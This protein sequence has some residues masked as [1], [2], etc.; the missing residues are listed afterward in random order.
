MRSKFILFILF[1]FCARSPG[2]EQEPFE[3]KA[4]QDEEGGKMPYR[5]FIPE[6]YKKDKKYP[7][8]I[9]LHGKG[10]KGNDNLKQI[11]TPGARVHAAVRVNV[12]ADRVSGPKAAGY[13]AEVG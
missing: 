13:T 9:F 4:Y 10:R 3:A 6:G 1:F 11:Q 2:A 7:L 12:E 8:V 5:L